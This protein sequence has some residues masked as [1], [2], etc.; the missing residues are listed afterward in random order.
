MVPR[1]T[2]VLAAAALALIAAC[3]PISDHRTE[4][5]SRFRLT[6]EE[7]GFVAKGELFRIYGEAA[8]PVIVDVA[9]TETD[10]DGQPGWR[11][12]TLVHILVDD[13]IQ[14]RRWR[15]WIALDPDGFPAVLQGQEIGS[16]PDE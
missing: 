2:V 1:I 5:E 9:A 16:V 12:D 11:L 13:Q 4:E 8:D 14:E 15:L 7:A 6:V 10:I 3:G